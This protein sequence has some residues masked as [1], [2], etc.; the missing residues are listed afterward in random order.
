MLFVKFWCRIF[1]KL[2]FDDLN[3]S[4]NAENKTLTS[5]AK[6]LVSIL[7]RNNFCG[8]LPLPLNYIL[9]KIA[10]KYNLKYLGDLSSEVANEVSNE[11]QFEIS[12]ETPNDLNQNELKNKKKVI[13][14]MK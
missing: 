2:N 12:L 10:Y 1:E 13:V 4:N 5:E 8:K 9:N 3:S 7:D 11:Q 14:L 6:E